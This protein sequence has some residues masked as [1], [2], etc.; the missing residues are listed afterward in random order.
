M[1]NVT[2]EMTALLDE[3]RAR[4]LEAIGDFS[5][6]TVIRNWGNRGDDL[7]HAG[8]RC[9]FRQFPYREYD[10]RNLDQTAG[11]KTAVVTG[12][13]AFC[14]PFHELPGLLPELE[15]R[16]ART[17]ILPSS[18]DIQEPATREFLSRTQGIVFARETQSYEQIRQLCDA[19][20]AC[21]SAFYFNFDPYRTGFSGGTLNAFR[22]DREAVGGPIPKGNRDISVECA[23]MDEWLWAISRH[24]LIRTDRAHVIIAAAMLGK[25]V[26]FRP[27]NYHK[28]PAIVEY[29]RLPSDQVQA[30]TPDAPAR[31]WFSWRAH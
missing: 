30:I 25:R 20:L 24:D 19:R 5:E 3:S 6:V 23:T 10:I 21:D 15:R 2:P 7:I 14:K 29:S 17:V 11:G 18:F 1:K 9:L 8:V 31:R 22:C 26:E 16:F 13:G 12:G 28:V 4:V 27:S